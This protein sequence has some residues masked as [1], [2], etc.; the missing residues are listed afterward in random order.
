MD[1]QEDL[2]D[3]FG[4]YIGPDLDSSDDESSSDDDESSVGGSAADG[5]VEGDAVPDEAASDVSVDPGGGW[6]APPP[7]PRGGR[8][9]LGRSGAATPSTR[10]P[11]PPRPP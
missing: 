3:E 6:R 7:P 4:N 11:G 2:Y 8:L 5:P 1:D 9:F 10:G